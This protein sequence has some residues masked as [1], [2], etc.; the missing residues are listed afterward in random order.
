LIEEMFSE[1]VYKKLKENEKNAIR[2]FLETF[3]TIQSKSFYL[4]RKISE[5]MEDSFEKLSNWSTP[6]MY[7]CLEYLLHFLT[8]WL[9]C[10][11]E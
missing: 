8:F 1:E 11:S 2:K 7:A 4:L 10:M 3:K 5:F 9:E 6:E